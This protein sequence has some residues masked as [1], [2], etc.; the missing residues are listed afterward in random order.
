MI[1]PGL[2]GPPIDEDRPLPRSGWPCRQYPVVQPLAE[3]RPQRITRAHTIIHSVLALQSTDSTA[4][5]FAIWP[6][7]FEGPLEKMSSPDWN[8][9]DFIGALLAQALVKHRNL[10]MAELV[11]QMRAALRR[12]A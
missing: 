1:R 11:A 2:P 5:S 7:F 4:R 8:W 3:G 12:A 10:L 9:A 6:W